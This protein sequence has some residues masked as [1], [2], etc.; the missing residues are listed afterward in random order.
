MMA[1]NFQKLS[2]CLNSRIVGTLSKLTSAVEEGLV[3]ETYVVEE[4]L[5]EARPME[6]VRREKFGK[7]PKYSK[8]IGRIS[9]PDFR[10]C[11][12]RSNYAPDGKV[13]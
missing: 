11:R 9:G 4:E 3:E 13:I 7:S 6:D 10:R 2:K 12:R 1:A 5:A 8:F